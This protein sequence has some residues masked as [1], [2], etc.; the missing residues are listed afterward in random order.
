MEAQDL[1]PVCE[2][3]CVPCSC[4]VQQYLQHNVDFTLSVKKIHSWPCALWANPSS[5]YTIFDLVQHGVITR[6]FRVVR[7]LA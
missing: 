6:N 3:S 2:G 7:T 4:G 5:G 1:E